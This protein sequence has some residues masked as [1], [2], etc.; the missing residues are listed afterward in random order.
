MKTK[1]LS[2]S[3][4]RA[5]SA[6]LTPRMASLRCIP[7]QHALGKHI[8]GAPI[9]G[10][11]IFAIVMLS[12]ST[13]TIMTGSMGMALADEI[14]STMQDKIKDG[15]KLAAEQIFTYRILDDIKTFDPQLNSDV[16]G[17]EVLRDLFEGLYNEDPEGK[18]EPGVAKSY[19][20]SDDKTVYTFTLRDAKW[21]DG[22]PVKASDFVFAWRRL[23]DP[24]TA[25]E[26]A[27]YME[28]MGVKNANA[29]TSGKMK[30]EMLGVKALDDHRFEV[31]LERPL[32]Y[33]IAMAAHTS[34]FPV[35]QKVVEKFGKDWAKPDRI[36]SNGA[37]VLSDYKSGEKVVR[38]R[39]HLYWDND[40]TIINKTVTLIINDENQ[41]LTRYKAGELDKTKV[42]AGKFPRLAKELPKETHS[43]PRSC[44]YIYWFNL[45]PN[46]PEYLKDVRV[47]K[48]LSYAIDRNIIVDKILRAGQ[49]PSYNFTHQKTA[50]FELPNIPY[51]KWSQKERDAKAKALLKEAGYGPGGKPLQVQIDYNTDEAH[52][53]IAIAVAQ[54]W[55]KK[56][57]AKVALNNY[58]WKVHTDRMQK[59]NYQIARY[60]WCGDY[61]EPSTYLDLLTSYS[62]HNSSKYANA[63]YDILLKE[64]KTMVE[65]MTNYQKA[66]QLLAKD[67]PFA[68]IY[69]YTDAI[70]LQ[71]DVHGW[72]FDNLTQ[73]WYSRKLYKTAE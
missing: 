14:Q 52:K 45:G 20:L 27:W 6:I 7:D 64:A 61:N 29:V 12:I 22:T 21:S 44:S 65:P 56:L 46:G 36:V 63:D 39:N 66:E 9:F 73:R 11:A 17:S 28:L 72:P 18:P 37:Y 57:G 42:P 2:L 41:A 54:F 23:A 4:F 3:I 70:M 51:A 71:P 5:K 35:P 53:K 68:P 43:F 24:K 13:F 59:G 26:Y 47:R 16:N 55:K 38:E 49:Y 62:G 8:L 31:T 15:Q 50:G 60:G 30:P 40:N 34:T 25:S 32:P 69:Q 58:E 67:M 10:T 19:K 48:A 1:L 33:F